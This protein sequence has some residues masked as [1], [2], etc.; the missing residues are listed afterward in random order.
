MRLRLGCVGAVC[1]G[2]LQGVAL[3]ESGCVLLLGVWCKETLLF[4]KA[5]HLIDVIA[6]QPHAFKHTCHTPGLDSRRSPLA[7]RR[8]PA[9]TTARRRPVAR[10]PVALAATRR[11]IALA[12]T[13]ATGLKAGAT[14]RRPAVVAPAARRPTVAVAAGLKAAAAHGRPARGS[15]A[16]LAD[17][18]CL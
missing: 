18:K 16:V 9:R 15:R 5:A 12:A 11:P 6:P 17:P 3:C 14:H 13:V 7:R 4:G 1:A 2:L 10:R 8:I